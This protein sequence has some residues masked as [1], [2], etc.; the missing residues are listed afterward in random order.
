MIKLPQMICSLSRVEL[1]LTHLTTPLLKHCSGTD[2]SGERLNIK[3]TVNEPDQLNTHKFYDKK[4]IYLH[5]KFNSIS[6][7]T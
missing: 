2:P 6:F 3:T 1:V 4:S 5:F 7:V